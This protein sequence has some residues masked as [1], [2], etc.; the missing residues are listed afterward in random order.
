[1]VIANYISLVPLSVYCCSKCNNNKK[2]LLG[3]FGTECSFHECKLSKRQTSPLQSVL[4]KSK[5]QTSWNKQEFQN[6][7]LFSCTHCSVFCGKK[8]YIN[9]MNLAEDLLDLMVT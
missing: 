9:D 8:E 7:F 6:S 5:N 2:K 3:C 1:M 4:M